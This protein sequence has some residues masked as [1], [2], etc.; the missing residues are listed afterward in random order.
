[1]KKILTLLFIG[2]PILIASSEGLLTPAITRR[3]VLEQV[4][5]QIKLA[6]DAGNTPDIN[7]VRQAL[8]YTATPQP[9][10]EVATAELKVEISKPIMPDAEMSTLEWFE[11]ALSQPR[12]DK[13]LRQIAINSLGSVLTATITSPNI[14]ILR[15]A[16]KYSKAGDQLSNIAVKSLT[17]A[18]DA[19]PDI[20]LVALAF[21]Y[22]NSNDALKQFAIKTLENILNHAITDQIAPNPSWVRL[23]FKNSSVSVSLWQITVDHVTRVFQMSAKTKTPLSPEWCA[24]GLQYLP[25]H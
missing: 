19:K 13:A 23:A 20:E 25:R 7:L 10:H 3:A 17:E 24:I 22:A 12:L 21:E 5:Q 9:L 18:A 4:Q 6:S 16:L 1:M 14:N 2:L 8:N 11:L 15:L